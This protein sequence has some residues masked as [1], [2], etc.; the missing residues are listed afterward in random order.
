MNKIILFINSYRKKAA[1]FQNNLLN[2]EKNDVFASGLLLFPLLCGARIYGAQERGYRLG[3][4]S[5]R[6][7]PSTTLDDGRRSFVVAFKIIKDERRMSECLN[8]NGPFPRRRLRP[9]NRRY[10]C[11]YDLASIPYA[12]RPLHCYL[13]GPLA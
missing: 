7:G 6:D 1:K 13:I 4:S 8:R 5:Q 3:R 10:G 12:F 9:K 2:K 11:R